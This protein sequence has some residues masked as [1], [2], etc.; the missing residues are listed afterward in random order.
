MALPDHCERVSGAASWD[1]DGPYYQ[2]QPDGS[3]KYI[4]SFSTARMAVP[5]DPA[6]QGQ[7]TTSEKQALALAIFRQMDSVL[8][9]RY[10]SRLTLIDPFGWTTFLGP[11]DAEGMTLLHVYVDDATDY[12]IAGDGHPN[13]RGNSLFAE[14][15]VEHLQG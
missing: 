6:L 1:Q 7:Y 15:I 5:S 4:G 14:V 2:L 12:T 9:D 10:N 13:E 3:V 11:M 8:Q